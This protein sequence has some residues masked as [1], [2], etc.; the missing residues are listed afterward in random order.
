MTSF[1][2]FREDISRAFN[3]KNI[4]IFKQ[5]SGLK[6]AILFSTFIVSYKTRHLFRSHGRVHYAKCNVIS[7]HQVLYRIPALHIKWTASD[8]ASFI[9]ELFLQ[10]IQ[11]FIP[12]MREKSMHEGLL[13]SI[14]LSHLMHF[15]SLWTHPPICV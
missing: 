2:V 4:S 7:F 15:V 14:A 8:I 10:S 9:H 5:A 11:K 6:A 12:K 1:Y 3:I 13:I